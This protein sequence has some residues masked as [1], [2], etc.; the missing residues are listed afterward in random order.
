MSDSDHT[1]GGGWDGKRA[2][3]TPTVRVQPGQWGNVICC[4]GFIGGTI[5]CM[6]MGM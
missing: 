1:T 4:V 5:C 3:L 6:G 2:S